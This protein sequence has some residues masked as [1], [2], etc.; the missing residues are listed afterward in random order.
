MCG[1]MKLLDARIFNTY[2][3]YFMAVGSGLTHL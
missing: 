3:Y 2:E 1:I